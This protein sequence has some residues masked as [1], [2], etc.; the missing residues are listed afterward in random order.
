MMTAEQKAKRRRCIFEAYVVPVTVLL[1]A[2]CAGVALGILLTEACAAEP[3]EPAERAPMELIVVEPVVDEPVVELLT[4][5]APVEVAE[6]AEPALPYTEEE[7][8]IL[9]III[10][11]EAGG[12][13]CSDET[14]QM[15]GEVFLNRV[16]SGRYP[17]TFEEVATQKKQYGRL[18]WTGLKWPDRASN[19]GE[20]HAVARAYE[21]AEAL[22]T[23]TV[24][25]LLPEGTIFQAEFPQGT[26]VVAEQD[27][28]YFCR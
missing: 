13:A 28:F 26:E 18:Y 12:D 20:A 6:T 19:P 16:A 5:V 10:Y 25:R 9:A 4:C 23:G 8:E 27:G 15:V 14:R 21:C 1:A 3:V 11:Q 24:E 7:L 17:D 22:L 2:L